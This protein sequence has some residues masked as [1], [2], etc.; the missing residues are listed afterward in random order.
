MKLCGLQKLT[1][2]DYPGKTACTVFLGGC[3]F[4]CPFCQN[5]ELLSLDTAPAALSL[6]T[7]LDFLKKRRNLLDG[8]CIT[9]GEP[10]LFPDVID[11]IREIKTLGYAVKLDTN[12]SF[13]ERLRAL[14][15]AGLI[16]YV[17][18]DIKNSPARYPETAG[19]SRL[20][21]SKIQESA[22]FL[23][24]GDLPYEFRTTVV[25]EFHTSADLMEIGKWL[26]GA[27]QYFLQAFADSEYVL[28]PGL[29]SLSKAEMQGLAAAVRPWIPS[30]AIR[31][32]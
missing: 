21:F 5:G 25:Q 4:R 23:L 16:D 14:A 29:H 11:L 19:L 26:Q 24:A 31:G 27:K 32:I 13:P 17:A 20:D 15:G 9:G 12:G 2:L 6:D 22:R 28:C 10:L 1:L 7:L 18:M 3:N 30:T 8:V